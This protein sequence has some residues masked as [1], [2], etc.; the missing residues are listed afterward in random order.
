MTTGYC[1][2]DRQMMEMKDVE[3]KVYETSRGTKYGVI[4]FCINCGTKM[5]KLVKKE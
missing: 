5:S 4:G 1:V 2:K 3:N